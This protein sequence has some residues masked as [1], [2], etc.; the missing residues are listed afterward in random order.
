MKRYYEL[1]VHHVQQVY[2]KWKCLQ[3][4]GATLREPKSLST[5]LNIFPKLK[6]LSY[7]L[8][9]LKTVEEDLKRKKKKKQI[10]Q[11]KIVEK[12]R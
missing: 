9:K 3:C 10:N 4:Q 7:K 8:Q 2:V 11:I 6:P 1:C 5:S 12:F